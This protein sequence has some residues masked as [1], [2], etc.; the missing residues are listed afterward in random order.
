M[1]WLSTPGKSSCPPLVAGGMDAEVDL[2]LGELFNDGAQPAGVG[3][4]VHL[5]FELEFFDDVL[6]VFGVSIEV[7]QEV[8]LHA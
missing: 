5:L 8:L 3:E 2:F 1:V 6:Y 7:L 4:V